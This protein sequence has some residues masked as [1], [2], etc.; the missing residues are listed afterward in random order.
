MLTPCQ[1][2]KALDRQKIYAGHHI[3]DEQN[4]HRDFEPRKHRGKGLGKL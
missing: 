3:S 1:R 2:T 4:V